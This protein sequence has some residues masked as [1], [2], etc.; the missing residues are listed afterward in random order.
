MKGI[1]I[2][3]FWLVF[4]VASPASTGDKVSRAK[5]YDQT[6]NVPGKA[7]NRIFQI[8]LENASFQASARRYMQRLV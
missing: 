2:I 5:Q 1:F 3:L 7:F 4:A 8:W 6:S